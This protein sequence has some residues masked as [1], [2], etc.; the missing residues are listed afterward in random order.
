M[1]I[2]QKKGNILWIIQETRFVENVVK[3]IILL[4][5]TAHAMTHILNLKSPAPA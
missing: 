4:V 5:K 2:Y 3:I 1:A